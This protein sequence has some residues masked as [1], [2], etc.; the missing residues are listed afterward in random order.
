MRLPTVRCF[1][2]DNVIHV[3][4]SIN[5][6]ADIEVINTELALADL[7]SVE[8]ALVRFSKAAKAKMPMPLR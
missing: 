2:D 6:A 7:D 8:K 5:P 1:D 4:G 3:E